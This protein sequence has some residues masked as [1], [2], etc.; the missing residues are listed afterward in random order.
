MSAD[1]FVEIRLFQD[2]WRWADG[3]DSQ[4]NFPENKLDD[5]GM[6]SLDRFTNGP[7]KTDDECY[8]NAEETLFF[9]EYG[10]TNVGTDEDDPDYDS[11]KLPKFET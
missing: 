9:I 5:G 11:K 4:D 3:T 7:F 6:L 10:I 2:G 1:N 8:N